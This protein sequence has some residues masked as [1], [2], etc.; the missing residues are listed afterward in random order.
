MAGPCSVEDK[1]RMMSIARSVKEAGATIL[2]GGAFKP[3]TSPY[4]FQ[5]LGEEGLKILRDAGGA[6][7]LAT[8]TEVMDPRDLDLI[9]R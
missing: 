6:N 4:D 9:C 7:N 2:R 1:N 5:G 3:R 8:V